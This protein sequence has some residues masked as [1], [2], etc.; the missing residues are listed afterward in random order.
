MNTSTNAENF[1]PLGTKQDRFDVDTLIAVE[2]A[3]GQR[4]LE[5]ITRGPARSRPVAILR[6]QRRQVARF[7][8]DAG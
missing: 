2:E 8:D 1:D 4:V 7:A 6:R 3:L 5:R